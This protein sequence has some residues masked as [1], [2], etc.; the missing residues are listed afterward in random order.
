MSCYLRVKSFPILLLMGKRNIHN[1]IGDVGNG[2]CAH[3]Y[4]L[5]FCEG[6]VIKL[7]RFYKLNWALDMILF[8]EMANQGSTVN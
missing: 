1:C 7:L 6:I 3:K 4:G 8:L 2:V 5:K